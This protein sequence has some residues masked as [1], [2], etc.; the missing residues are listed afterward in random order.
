VIWVRSSPAG[1]PA[2]VPVNVSLVLVDEVLVDV[3]LVPLDVSLVL[4][5]EVLVDVS[6]LDEVEVVGV[7]SGVD[8][9]VEVPPENGS[10]V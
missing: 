6:L 9:D 8:E 1:F 5:D 4:V 7:V 2:T 10:R 3:S